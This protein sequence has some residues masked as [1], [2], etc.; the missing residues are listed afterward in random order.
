MI[1]GGLR[2]TRLPT[3]G[4]RRGWLKFS[5]VSTDC[6]YSAI[7]PVSNPRL[8]AMTPKQNPSPPKPADDSLRMDGVARRAKDLLLL[9]DLHRRGH[10][11][12]CPSFFAIRKEFAQHTEASILAWCLELARGGHI[13]V[14]RSNR[15][16]TITRRAT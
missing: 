12:Q 14:M 10:S 2:L 15:Q 7:L 9:I 5:G 3:K 11:G 4:Y 8:Y 1:G 16:P 6:K 13:T